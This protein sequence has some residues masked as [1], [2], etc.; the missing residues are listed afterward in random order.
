MIQMINFSGGPKQY[1]GWNKNTAP[2]TVRPNP[3]ELCGCDNVTD[4]NQNEGA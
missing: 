4:L 3:E 1:I 2:G